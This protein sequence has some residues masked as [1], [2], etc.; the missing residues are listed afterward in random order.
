M[1]ETP[2]IRWDREGHAH[3]NALHWEGFSRLLWES[4][5]IFGYDAPPRYDWYEFVEAGVP[6]CRVKMTIPQHPSRYLWQ[7]VT[8]C[9][10]GHRLVDTFESAALEA[11][12]IFCDKH[13]RKWQPTR[14]NCSQPQILVTPSGPSGSL[15][16]VIY[17]EICLS[18]HCR[19][20]SGSWTCNIIISCYNVGAWT[21]C[22]P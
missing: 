13:P 4:L 11:I 20:L 6:R 14:S 19:L 18:R 8:I 7:P 5:Q 15:A 2:N 12:H 9:I 16:A 1:A 17:W 10:T 3:T 21:S 22:P